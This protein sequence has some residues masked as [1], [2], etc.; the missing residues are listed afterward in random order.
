MDGV[1]YDDTPLEKDTGPDIIPKDQSRDL[2]QRAYDDSIE[3]SEA[4]EKVYNELVN[5]TVGETSVHTPSPLTPNHES[6]SDTPEKTQGQILSSGEILEIPNLHSKSYAKHVPVPVAEHNDTNSSHSSTGS[7]GSFPP[8]YDYAVRNARMYPSYTQNISEGETAN[9]AQSYQ[10]PPPCYPQ[11]TYSGVIDSSK[12]TASYQTPTEINQ[13]ATV[14]SPSR[15][16]GESFRSNSVKSENSDIVAQAQSATSSWNYYAPVTGIS[17]GATCTDYSTYSPY[18]EY[19]RQ[20]G[21]QQQ[22]FPD[23]ESRGPADPMLPVQ[24]DAE[25]IA[26]Y[27]AAQ[28]QYIDSCASTSYPA[29]GK[30]DGA[31]TGQGHFKIPSA[32][33]QSQ[34]TLVAQPVR[35]SKRVVVPAGKSFYVI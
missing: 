24:A 3:P 23:A 15:S 34:E 25:D 9:L 14:M 20:Y 5:D 32:A 1:I 27:A 12:T 11:G 16:T 30:Q 6:A 4:G 31:H 21:V 8:G 2:L 22:S 7:N 19:E 18:A 28:Q 33:N 29:T 35:K 10:E 17:T 13:I 26:A